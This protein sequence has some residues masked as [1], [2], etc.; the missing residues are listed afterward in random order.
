MEWVAITFSRGFSWPRDK[1]HTLA[2][3]ADSLPP[4]PP[5]NPVTLNQFS[6]SVVSDSLWPCLLQHTTLPC[7]S[8]TPRACPNSCSSQW[9]HPTIS[10][11]VV[12][13]S[14][15]NTAIQKFCFYVQSSLN[16]K[17]CYVRVHYYVIWKMLISPSILV[18][19]LLL[20]YICW[21]IKAKLLGNFFSV[22]NLFR[23]NSTR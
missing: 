9:S 4:D 8:S 13:F 3:Q 21:Y 11:F 18:S 16:F 17:L 1:S 2:L 5:G 22:Y 10:S 6:C 20:N 14:P 19:H 23:K 15:A 7:P 12:P